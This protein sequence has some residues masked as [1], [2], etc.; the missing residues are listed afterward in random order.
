MRVCCLWVIIDLLFLQLSSPHSF[1]LPHQT[2]SSL[3]SLVPIPKRIACC[4]GASKWGK[5]LTPLCS[6]Y[7]GQACKHFSSEQLTEKSN[8]RHKSF[9]KRNLSANHNCCIAFPSWQGFTFFFGWLRCYFWQQNVFVEIDTGQCQPFPKAWGAL[10]KQSRR[11]KGL[12]L[13]SSL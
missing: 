2:F 1:L 8:L 3:R 7:V 10:R 6:C 4:E 5:G 11:I 12:I 9:M 13:I